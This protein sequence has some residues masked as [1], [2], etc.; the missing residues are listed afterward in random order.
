MGNFTSD[1]EGKVD[2]QGF[3]F[4]EKTK[5]ELVETQTVSG[6]RL[7]TRPVV[8]DTGY[9]AGIAGFNGT[10]EDLRITCP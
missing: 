2:F 5:Y 3:L 7:D 10:I 1:A 8:I 9:E 4:E 6:Y